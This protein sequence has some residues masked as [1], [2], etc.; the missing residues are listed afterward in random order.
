MVVRNNFE[1][2]L[3]EVKVQI[4]TMGEEVKKSLDS[5][6]E[7]FTTN[8]LETLEG[9]IHHDPTINGMELHINEMVTLMIAKQQPVASDLRKLI[10]ALKISSDLERV[11]DLTVDIAKNSIRVKHSYIE[12]S[13][14]ELL[15]IASRAQDMLSNALD[16]YQ[17]LD[18]LGAQKIAQMDD[19][20]DAMYSNFIKDLM[21]K[22][23]SASTS[24]EELLQLA[25]IGRYVER[26]ADYATNL[27]EWVV[28]EVNGQYFDLN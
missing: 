13:K 8:N 10:V 11:G 24:A 25:F 18:V 28:Y 23:N 3:E 20:V 27:A 26:I 17:N 4:V 2:A 6:L 16:A 9:V 21:K 19:V 12:E 15:S 1:H 14:E 22:A 7:G 5:V